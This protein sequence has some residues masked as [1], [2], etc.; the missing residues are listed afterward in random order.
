LPEPSAPNT[1]KLGALAA[2][3]R[4]ETLGPL[5][6]CVGKIRASNK[7]CSRR[8]KRVAPGYV[9][10]RSERAADIFY[11]VWGR[12]IIRASAGQRGLARRG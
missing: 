4:I 6:E 8:L 5:P 2:D 3:Y 9:P 7:P 12:F 1:E 10:Q 11:D